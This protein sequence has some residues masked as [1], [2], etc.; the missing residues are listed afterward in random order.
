MSTVVAIS[1]S[2]QSK[3]ITVSPPTMPPSASDTGSVFVGEAG[4]ELG[5]VSGATTCLRGAASSDG[6]GPAPGS[7]DSS[8][9]AMSLNSASRV[10][11]EHAGGVDRADSAP[12][13]VQP[14]T[15]LQQSRKFEGVDSALG[16]LV[17][18]GILGWQ[19]VEVIVVEKLNFKR[20]QEFLPRLVQFLAA[21]L[22]ASSKMGTAVGSLLV[23]VGI[24]TLIKIYQ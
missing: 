13:A 16:V 8:T 6:A 14:S 4:G 15:A 24:P 17:W 11:A 23:P 2:S 3:T 20:C 19:A 12:A 7:L 9:G 18:S 5:G 21:T 1:V 10:G 22:P